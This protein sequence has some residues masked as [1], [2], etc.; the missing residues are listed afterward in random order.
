MQS[1]KVTLL[2]TGKV[3]FS[4]A[5]SEDAGFDVTAVLEPTIKGDSIYLPTL[6][7]EAYM[8]IDYIEYHTGIYMQPEDK[9]V[10]ALAYPR[11]SV[12]KYRLQLCNSV[13]VI[14]NGY[15]GEIC[16]RFNYL[17]APSDYRI[18][19]GR[20]YIVPNMKKIY[21]KGDKIGQIIFAKRIPVE[22]SFSE[23]LEETSRGSGGFGSTG[24]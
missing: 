19:D 9:D 2:Q 11:S 23:T 13:G 24:K 6:N 7:C 16:L 21:Q 18:I 15:R 8:A 22:V 20:L 12:S 17:P 5:H 4:T 14:D 3:E 10:F 1:T